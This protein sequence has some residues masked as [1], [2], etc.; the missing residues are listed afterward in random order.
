MEMAYIPALIRRQAGKNIKIVTITGGARF[1]ALQSGK[2][3]A[4]LWQNGP[5]T[6][7]G[8]AAP[9]SERL[10]IGNTEYLTT[11]SY[12]DSYDTAL[13]RKK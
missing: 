13:V 5:V 1:T 3:D 11:E 6:D 10:K 4:F 7:L 9:V 8:G 2:I 12:L